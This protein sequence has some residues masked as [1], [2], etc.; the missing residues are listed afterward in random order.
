MLNEYLTE[1]IRESHISVLNK[2]CSLVQLKINSIREATSMKMRITAKIATIIIIS[3][4]LFIHLTL[5]F[6]V[7]YLYALKT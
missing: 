3:K 2:Y 7:I 6:S 1:D 5:K 4:Y